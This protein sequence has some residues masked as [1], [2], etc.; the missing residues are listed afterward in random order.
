VHY[1]E[2]SSL[3]SASVCFR[4]IGIKLQSKKLGGKITIKISDRGKNT[5]IFYFFYFFIRRAGS[6]RRAEAVLLAS[7]V[8]IG[9][10]ASV[11]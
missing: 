8:R 9:G 1:S 11:E 5:I 10:S 6:L 7:R 4:I 2:K 3:R